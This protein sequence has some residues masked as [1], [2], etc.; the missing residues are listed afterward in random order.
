MAEQ[1]SSTK[2]LKQTLGFWDLMGSAVGQIIGAGIMSLMPA[3]IAITGRS[4]PFAFLIAA[5]ITCAG[6]I[7]YIFICSCVRLRGGAYTQLALLAGKTFAGMNVIT[8]I[9]GN[10]SLG[11]YGL[12]LAAYLC[13]LFGLPESSQKW[14]GL[15]VLTLFYVLNLLGIDAFAKIQNALVI[16]LIGSLLM[17]GIMGITKVQ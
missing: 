7:P 12:S 16:V 11:M 10:M 3:A 15:A 1:G 9:L 8:G 13:P 14:V 2:Q 4:V 17:F 6:A 5:L